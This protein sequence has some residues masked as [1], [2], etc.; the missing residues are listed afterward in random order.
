MQKSDVIKTNTTS[1]KF[2]TVFDIQTL[3]ISEESKHRK[4]AYVFL[5]SYL[6][7][8][9]FMAHTVWNNNENMEAILQEKKHLNFI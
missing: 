5:L 7:H 6:I 1:Q 2:D 8:Q 3:S 9:V 4:F